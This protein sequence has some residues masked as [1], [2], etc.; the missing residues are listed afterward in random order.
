MLGLHAKL[1]ETFWGPA[2]SEKASDQREIL[3]LGSLNNSNVQHDM[4]PTLFPKITS[5]YCTVY[6]RLGQFVSKFENEKYTVCGKL[7]LPKEMERH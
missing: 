3:N 5:P 6:S 2:P 7:I 4:C 1:S